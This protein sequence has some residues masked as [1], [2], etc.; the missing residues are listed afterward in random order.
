ME[1]FKKNGYTFYGEGVYIDSKKIDN[2]IRYIIKNKITSIYINKNF[3]FG[4]NNLDFL[5]D[6]D[7]IDDISIESEIKDFSGLNYLVNL[8]KLSISSMSPI[9]QILDFNNF[10]K[11]EFCNIAPNEKV[12]NLNQCNTLITLNLW[13][14]KTENLNL[15]RGLSNLK[16]L[17][18]FNSNLINLK[19]TEQLNSLNNVT[20][21]GMK[22]LESIESLLL[23]KDTLKKLALRKCK[24]FKQYNVIQEFENLENLSLVDCGESQTT[25]FFKSLKKLIYCYSEVNI[26]DGDVSILMQMPVMFKNYKHYNYKNNLKIKR[27]KND[28]SYLIRGKETLYKLF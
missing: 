19:G 5:K 25:S 23:S 3:G 2:S 6:I 20:L 10:P 27:I 16:E 26:L 21:E 9:K 12:I 8:K 15:I 7:F 22:N 17:C 11:L 4:L 1:T 13:A 24:K 14:L 18:I 28:G